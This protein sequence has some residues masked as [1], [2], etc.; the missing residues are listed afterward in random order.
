[1][2]TVVVQLCPTEVSI[3]RDLKWTSLPS[4]SRIRALLVWRKANISQVL[5]ERSLIPQ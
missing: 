5:H 2:T 3:L 1:M 4:S